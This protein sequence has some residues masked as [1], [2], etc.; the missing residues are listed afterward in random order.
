MS[1]L[2][3]GRCLQIEGYQHA[4]SLGRRRR[5]HGLQLSSA[6]TLILLN[7]SQYGLLDLQRGHELSLLQALIQRI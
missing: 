1:L 4:I 2:S 7:V 3:I 5:K 6:V